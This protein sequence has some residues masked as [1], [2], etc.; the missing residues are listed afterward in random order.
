MIGQE[1]L[2]KDAIEL[3]KGNDEDAD[4]DLHAVASETGQSKAN[5]GTEDAV[6]DVDPSDHPGGAN[7]ETM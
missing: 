3:L 1:R 4:T 2:V 6:V 5:R 7:S